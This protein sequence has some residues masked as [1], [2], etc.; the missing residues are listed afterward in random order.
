MLSRKSLIDSLFFFARK[1]GE[2]NAQFTLK[3]G[4]TCNIFL[5]RRVRNQEIEKWKESVKKYI[6][7]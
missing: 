6:W 1:Q 7:N 5:T 4:K 3:I 2:G